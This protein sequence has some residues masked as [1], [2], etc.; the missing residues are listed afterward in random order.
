MILAISLIRPI[1]VK[2]VSKCVSFV[3][4]PD[5]STLQ[6][7]FPSQISSSKNPGVALKYSP[8]D[9]EIIKIA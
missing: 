2:V 7:S 3:G 4:Q 5:L 8:E 1:P 9:G 6:T